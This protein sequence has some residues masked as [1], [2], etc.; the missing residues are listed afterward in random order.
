MA[1]AVISATV[2][3]QS[4]ARIVDRENR[5]HHL[6]LAHQAHHDLGDQRHGAFRARQQARQIVAR[7]VR[8]FAAGGH[9]GAVGQH[10]LEAQHMIGGDAVGQRVR[11]AG[12]L[13]DV[14]ADRAGALA[15]RIG[16]VEITVRCT[17]SVISRLTTPGLHHRALV[18]Q[19]D[20][21]DPVHAREADHDAALTRNR[22]AA[23]S[24]ACAAADDR[25]VVLAR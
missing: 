16:R 14:A 17:A 6:G 25:N 9:D 24:R 19:I 3:P 22:A 12:V 18:F 1:R 15:G 11:P 10:D 21:E 23:E 5:L 20:L 13:R 7:R 2:A 4:S 8:R